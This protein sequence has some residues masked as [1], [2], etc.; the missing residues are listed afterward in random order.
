MNICERSCTNIELAHPKRDFSGEKSCVLVFGFFSIFTLENGE[1]RSALWPCSAP[2]CSETCTV[3]GH[4]L[5][6]QWEMWNFDAGGRRR[7]LGLHLELKLNWQPFLKYLFWMAVMCF[8]FQ[9]VCSWFTHSCCVSP[10]VI[11][12]EEEKWMLP[13]FLFFKWF[14]VTHMDPRARGQQHTCF[15]PEK[16]G[17]ELWFSKPY[18]L[19]FLIM[20]GLEMKY[21]PAAT[22]GST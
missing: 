14:Y 22:F 1:D 16:D 13:D 18:A 21:C 3:N 2:G 20:A 19:L 12:K 9:L 11:V 15:S 4:L 5:P 17:L 6:K 8:S 10:I 7:L